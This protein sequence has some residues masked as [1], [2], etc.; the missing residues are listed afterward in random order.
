M[1][2]Q[3]SNAPLFMLLTSLIL[4]TQPVFS[5]TIDEI[6]APKEPASRLGVGSTPEKAF[7]VTE[8]KVDIP[9]TDSA[10]SAA[11][12]VKDL[13][14]ADLSLKKISKE[15]AD[16]LDM[17]S[18]ETL[19]DLKLLW[20]GA[21]QHSETVKFIIYKLSNPDEDKPDKSIVKKIVRPLA[22]VG[23]MAGIGIGN[24]IGAISA[25]MGS[26]VVGNFSVDEKD[27][28]YRFTKVNDADMVVLIRKIEE[29]QRKICNYYF[30]Y[31]AARASLI[32]TDEIV[33]KRQKQFN[34][35]NNKS[36]EQILMADAYYRAAL[37][38]QSTAKADFLSKRAAL[39]QTVGMDTMAEFED[40]LSKR[41][42]Q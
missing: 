13:T 28:N 11:N 40:T 27:L 35:L 30:D 16:D 36:R 17:E 33:L 1:K 6:T 8:S 26:N 10:F 12:A 23:S 24:P 19:A 15:V 7:K 4:S 2:K 37:Q 22:T 32:K 9:T 29:L 38:L 14:Y 39:E 25:L 41:K 42:S 34:A 5:I 20:V 3:L 31:M 18:P 21:A